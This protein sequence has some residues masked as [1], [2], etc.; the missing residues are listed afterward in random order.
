MSDGN[1]TISF[2]TID[3]SPLIKHLNYSKVMIID[4][5]FL[6]ICVFKFVIGT[7]LWPALSIRR[8]VGWSVCHNFLKGRQFH[9]HAPIR[10][11]II[12][13]YSWQSNIFNYFSAYDIAFSNIL[14]IFFLVFQTS[15]E[16]VMVCVLFCF[17]YNLYMYVQI[18]RVWQL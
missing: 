1:N 12:W 9:F 16:I 5:I 10:A 14:L 18:Y 6:W 17:K 2:L 7:S 15:L 4:E 13:N 3:Y 8:L 11:L